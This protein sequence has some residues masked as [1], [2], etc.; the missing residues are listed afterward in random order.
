MTAKQKGKQAKASNGSHAVGPSSSTSTKSNPTWTAPKSITHP[1]HHHTLNHLNQVASYYAVL[2]ASSSSAAPSDTASRLQ[3][4]MVRS[5]KTL[6]RKAVIRM[7][8]GLKRESC[9][10]C[11]T[12]LMQG[13]TASL[14]SRVS[15]PHDH[16]VKARC[17]VCGTV[18]RRPAPDLVPRL[19]T[20]DAGGKGK[21]DNGDANVMEEESERKDAR[22][23]EDEVRKQQK[24]KVP[25]RQ[26]RR[27]ASIK[28]HLLRQTNSDANDPPASQTA[29]QGFSMV[30]SATS[31]TDKGSSTGRPSRRQIAEKRKA[32]IAN[33]AST[34]AAAAPAGLRE[35]KKHARSQP[36]YVTWDSPPPIP[37]A[38][39]DTSTPPPSEDLL[40]QDNAPPRRRKLPRA[41]RPQLPHFND[42]LQGS[43]W[44]DPL[45]R[46][47]SL[48][49]DSAPKP[50]IDTTSTDDHASQAL[51]FWQSAAHSRG[52]HLL[53]TGVGK[54]GALGPTVP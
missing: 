20:D 42:R 10:K 9:T 21:Q 30:P 5:A 50:P 29:P 38:L 26:R 44:D 6:S 2:S 14:R 47:S 45:T 8:T 25:Q 15:G 43:H 16:V 3:A 18:M 35:P 32:R 17:K 46:L 11:D 51:H 48:L 22:E 23:T 24:R 36:Y 7:D 41:P 40:R 39:E 33:R 27:T 31:T 1:E 12:V 13:L 4:E 49:A 19:I 53:V 54:N 37:V 28:R 34:S 52:D